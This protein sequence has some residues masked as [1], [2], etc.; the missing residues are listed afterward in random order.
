MI[1]IKAFLLVISIYL[2]VTTLLSFLKCEIWWIRVLDFPRLQSFWLQLACGAL[3][4]PLF[5]EGTPASHLLL[6]GLLLCSSLQGYMLLPYTFLVPKQVLPAT[7]N[8]RDRQ[9]NLV[10][11]NVLM[12]NRDAVRLL[13][14]IKKHDPDIV[15]C[16]ETDE[17][18]AQQ[19]QQLKEKYP[20][21]IE[22]PLS[23][24]Y[25]LLFYSRLKLNKKE[26]RYLIQDDIP[27]ILVDVE[28]LSGEVFRLYGVHPRPPLPGESKTSIPRDAELVV[29]GKEA[30]KHGQPCIVTGDLNDV[31]WSRTT[32]LF[33]EMSGLLDPRVGRGM[34]CSFNAKYFIFRWSLDHVFVS[35]HFRLRKLQRL[36]NIGSDH[37]P[38][39]ISLSYE[40]EKKDTSRKPDAEH[41]DHEE[42]EKKIRKAKG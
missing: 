23:N 19:L 33:Q 12:Y 30:K 38:I 39:Y 7:G 17:W 27:S 18:W 35:E 31:A 24:T 20:H 41:D 36:S 13:A 5:Y 28:L 9:L 8:S 14:E 6:G 10:I 34:Y 32:R 16:V 21:F 2:I 26:V 15:F 25:G 42:A 11:S 37:F 3:Y 29:V 40:P 22:L 1:V 4:I